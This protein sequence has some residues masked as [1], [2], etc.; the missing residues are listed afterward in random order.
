METLRSAT[1]GHG[2]SWAGT[3]IPDSDSLATPRPHQMAG[4]GHRWVPPGSS[5]EQNKATRGQARWENQAFSRSTHRPAL[6][7]RLGTEQS[8]K[9]TRCVPALK[10]QTVTQGPATWPPDPTV[11]C[12]TVPVSPRED[13]AS[14]LV[15]QTLPN[16]PHPCQAGAGQGRVTG[17]LWAST[18]SPWAAPPQAAPDQLPSPQSVGSLKAGDTAQWGALLQSSQAGRLP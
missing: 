1:Q 14:S 4:L 7:S 12:V 3:G 18:A 13:S 10:S 16:A 6:C 8:P 9:S 15:Q 17:A 11:L 2:K 5:E